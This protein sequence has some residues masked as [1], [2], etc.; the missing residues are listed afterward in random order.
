MATFGYLFGVAL[1]I[2]VGYGCFRLHAIWT[3]SQK[4]EADTA[5]RAQDR[6]ALELAA[7]YRLKRGLPITPL[8]ADAPDQTERLSGPAASPQ[9]PPS[10]R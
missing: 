9:R 5:R 2:A 7:S 1:I 3:K 8:R 4:D 6:F 10:G